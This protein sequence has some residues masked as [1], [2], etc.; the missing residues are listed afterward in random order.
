MWLPDGF[1]FHS[2][3]KVVETGGATT[4]LDQQFAATLTISGQPTVVT[5]FDAFYVNPTE[6]DENLGTLL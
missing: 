2:G 6:V 4:I 3:V 5:A 1:S